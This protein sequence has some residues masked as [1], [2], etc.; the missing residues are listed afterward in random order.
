MQTDGDNK[1]SYRACLGI[2]STGTEQNLISKAMNRFP[3]ENPICS[4]EVKS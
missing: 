1:D 2:K 3:Y 4:C